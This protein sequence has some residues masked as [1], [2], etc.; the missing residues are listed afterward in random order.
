[1]PQPCGIK[2]ISM[3]LH[4]PKPSYRSSTSNFNEMFILKIFSKF[5]RGGEIAL[6]KLH[7]II[8]SRKE[9]RNHFEC[10]K[11]S[12]KGKRSSKH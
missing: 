11:S 5:S 10:Q 6:H 1:M 9:K 8:F 2:K 12:F 7:F 3:S 4:N